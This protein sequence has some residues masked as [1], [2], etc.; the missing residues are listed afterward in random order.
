VVAVL[1]GVTLSAGHVVN[2]SDLTYPFDS[3]RM[4]STSS[5]PRAYYVFR[6]I[7]DDHGAFDYPFHAISPWSPGP[8]SGYSMLAPLTWR[9]VR[10]QGACRCASG[11]PELDDV[12]GA[13]VRVHERRTA[14]RVRAF[15]IVAAPALVARAG[16][17]ERVVYTWRQ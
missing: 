11:D 17:A 9:L 12:I 2:R 5:A 15:E 10:R 4:Y 13:L 1:L 16:A 8:L 6:V 3:W 7:G 14:A